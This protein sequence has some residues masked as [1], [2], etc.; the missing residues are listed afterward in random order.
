MANY[1]FFFAFLFQFRF[2][3]CLLLSGL[4]CM[5]VMFV[6]GCGVSGPV[7]RALDSG[8]DGLGSCPGWGTTLWP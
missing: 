5:V 3:N 7:V 4:N 8:S 2:H 1:A 6:C